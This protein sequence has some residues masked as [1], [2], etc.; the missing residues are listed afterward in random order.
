MGALVAGL[1]LTSAGCADGGGAAPAPEGV[2]R[3]AQVGAAQPFEKGGQRAWFHDE[4]NP[5]GFFHTYDAFQVAGPNDVPRKVHIYV[6]RDYETSGRSYPVVYMNDG[7]TAFFPG[8]LANKSWRVASALDGLYAAGAIEPVIVVAVAP[9]VRDREYTHEPWLF[10]RECCGL[11]GYVGYLADSVKGWVD[12]NYRT[13]PGP[14][15]TAIVGSSH[16]GLAA[17]YIANARPDRFGKAGCLSSSFWAGL[18]PG[19]LFGGEPLRDSL[20]LQRTNATLADRARRPRLW[21]DWGLVRSGGEHNSLVESMA[22]NRGREMVSLL[23][24]T[25]GYGPDELASREDP[26]G[27]HDEDSWARRFPDVMRFLFGNR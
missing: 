3:A 1:A 24:T 14:E 25:Y 6:P 2:D 20:L 18:D 13:R 7:D 9:L 27:G 10:G 22:T 15:S 4:G 26:Q 12:G 16:G 21:V 23:Q 8:G 11:D 17:F 19:F 5:S